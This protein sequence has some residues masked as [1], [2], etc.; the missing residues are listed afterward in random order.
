MKYSF[1]NYEFNDATQ[2][3]RNPDGSE[4]WLR[5]Q[6]CAL[7]SAF[8]RCPGELITTEDL[9]RKVWPGTS[10]EGE[11][12]LHKTISEL[13]QSLKD[14]KIIKSRRGKGY[15]FDIEPSS[16]S[17]EGHL[18]P[19]PIERLHGAVHPDV[20]LIFPG[21]GGMPAGATFTHSA[22]AFGA[23]DYVNHVSERLSW[24]EKSR[25]T[26]L[27]SPVQP[28]TL[29]FPVRHHIE[30]Q[31]PAESWWA[32]SIPVRINYPD[33]KWASEDLSSYK[34]LMFDAR[35]SGIDA[36]NSKQTKLLVRLEGL[37]ADP[38]IEGRQSTDWHPKS[39]L[40]TDSFASFE[41]DLD[42]WK[43]SA[44]SFPGN[45]TSPERNQ[46]T[47]ITLGQDET[48]PDSVTTIEIRNIRFLR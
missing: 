21:Q 26:A 27:L 16:V 32:A 39:P 33:G 34:S 23:N 45:A 7:L 35:A 18:S 10:F 47:Q 37:P 30:K 6:L 42:L 4:V 12:A 38:E 44:D 48:V 14:K 43:W 3:L 25:H 41:L 15:V 46:I 24:E 29:F 31:S 19:R 40:L 5:E 2:H 36:R 17:K 13:K 9:I 20:L 22:I 8:L 1:K 28:S 11:H